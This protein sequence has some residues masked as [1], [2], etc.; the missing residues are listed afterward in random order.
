M[1]VKRLHPA[2]LR[3]LGAWIAVMWLP[4]GQNDGITPSRTRMAVVVALVMAS[5]WVAAALF[6]VHVIP[7][8]LTVT[9]RMAA[10][11][12]TLRFSISYFPDFMPR[13][14]R[15]PHSQQH[16]ACSTPERRVPTARSSPSGLR[17]LRRQG[18]QWWWRGPTTFAP[19]TPSGYVTNAG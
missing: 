18:T 10:A 15:N 17:A 8:V 9:R 3:T 12:R 11:M 13:C 4:G 5:A 7:P 16:C 2:W 6:Q 14:P 19:S 1:A